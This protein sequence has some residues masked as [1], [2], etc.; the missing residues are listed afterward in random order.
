M[1]SAYT[2][3]QTLIECENFEILR[4]QLRKRDISMMSIEEIQLVLA[5]R[6]EKHNKSIK[7]EQ[8]EIRREIELKQDRIINLE[9]GIIDLLI[10]RG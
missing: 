2:D 10:T 7:K 5:D 3:R 9:K 1:G 6:I 8:E 4:Q